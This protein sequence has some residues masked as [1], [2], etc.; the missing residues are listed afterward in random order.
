MSYIKQNHATLP[1]HGANTKVPG[2][3]HR[4]E[5]IVVLDRAPKGIGS[6][7]ARIWPLLIDLFFPF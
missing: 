6:N 2:A 3:S 5:G 7:F 1:S 4:E